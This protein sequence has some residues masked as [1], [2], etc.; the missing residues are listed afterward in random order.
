M[1]DANTGKASSMRRFVLTV[2]LWAALGAVFG[3][4]ARPIA[5]LVG[6]S[7]SDLDR[8]F[9]RLPNDLSFVAAG[10]VSLIYVVC[11]LFG[12]AIIFQPNMA[13]DDGGLGGKEDVIENRVSYVW[14]ALAMTAAGAAMFALILAEPFGAIAPFAALAI[15]ALAM[16]LYCYAYWR[17][18]CLQDELLRAMTLEASAFAYFIMLGIGG[19]WAVLGHLG[20]VSGPEFL[21]WLTLFWTM[22]IVS[23]V[24]AAA[25]RGMI[26][27]DWTRRDSK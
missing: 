6:L 11:G 15:F 25:K 3:Y 14:Q 19:S 8:W 26:D 5:E 4:F 21:D 9:D 27:D 22:G 2:L 16:A 7:L 12:F 13:R 24:W 18:W 1:T 10:L 20:I 17:S 23:G